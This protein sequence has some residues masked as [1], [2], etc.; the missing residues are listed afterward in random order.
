MILVGTFLSNI[1]QDSQLGVYPMPRSLHPSYSKLTAHN[2]GQ[3]SRVRRPCSGTL[4]L[5]GFHRC[6]RTCGGR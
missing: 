6:G 5:P 3:C 1:I 2:T 4:Q